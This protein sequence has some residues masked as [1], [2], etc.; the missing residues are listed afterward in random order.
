MIVV[1]LY[2]LKVFFNQEFTNETSSNITFPCF[3]FDL[4]T[5]AYTSRGLLKAYRKQTRSEHAW[6][7]SLVEELSFKKICNFSII[8]RV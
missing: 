7:D 8:Y 3:K 4:K 5:F 2:A 1:I 6:N